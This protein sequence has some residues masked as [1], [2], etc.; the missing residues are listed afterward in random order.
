MQAPACGQP[1]AATAG[2]SRPFARLPA[3][4]SPSLLTCGALPQP[5]QRR[6]TCGVSLAGSMSRAGTAQLLRGSAAA[7]GSTAALRGASSKQGSRAALTQRGRLRDVTPQACGIIGIYKA[8]GDC[9]VEVYEGLLSL[10]VG[11]HGICICKIT[12]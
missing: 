8:S 5:A 3:R 7:L 9:N 6:L 12:L 11:A 10:Q 2:S 4:P 1:A